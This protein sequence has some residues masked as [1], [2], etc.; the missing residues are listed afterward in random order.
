MRVLYDVVPAV[1][2]QFVAR[3]A[4]PLS[5]LVAGSGR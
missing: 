2:W 5:S 3:T 4:I 1:D